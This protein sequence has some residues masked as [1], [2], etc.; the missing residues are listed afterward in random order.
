MDS[1]VLVASFLTDDH[2]HQRALEHIQDIESGNSVFHLPMLVWVEVIAS[3]NRQARKNRLALLSRAE[4]SLNSW[5]S[6]GKVVLYPLDRDRM[7]R[8][9]SVAERHRLR[10]AD[11]VVAALAEELD[12]P[13]RAFDREILE[14]F[15]R[16][17]P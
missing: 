12:L 4:Q 7:N 16:A 6:S 5:E 10:G 1:S 17:S 15:E 2:F 3:V 9:A 8:A 14:R 11:S 13:L